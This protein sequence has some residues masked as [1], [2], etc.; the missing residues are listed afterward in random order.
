MIQLKYVPGDFLF[1][2]VDVCTCKKLENG[3]LVL[4]LKGGRCK[5][6]PTEQLNNITYIDFSRIRRWFKAGGWKDF[7]WGKTGLDNRGIND[8]SGYML[9]F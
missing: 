6:Q 7:S 9:C 8:I 5:L 3:H 4:D 2:N 1:T